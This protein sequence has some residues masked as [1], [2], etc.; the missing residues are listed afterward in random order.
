MAQS[1]ANIRS[2]FERLFP[3]SYDHAQTQENM[4]HMFEKTQEIDKKSGCYD[5]LDNMLMGIQGN[6]TVEEFLIAQKILKEKR[7]ALIVNPEQI[8]TRSMCS[9][10]N[11]KDKYSILT[12]FN[13]IVAY[14]TYLN[15]RKQAIK[16]FDLTFKEHL[17]YANKEAKSQIVTWL[18]DLVNNL[19]TLKCPSDVKTKYATDLATKIFQQIEI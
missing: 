11:T 7:D 14:L 2:S 1:P 10:A 4:L 16:D 17:A 15:Q 5:D 3:A 18:S 8:F 6:S 19:D 13:L 12:R 9:L